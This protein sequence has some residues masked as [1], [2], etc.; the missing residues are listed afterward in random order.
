VFKVS[1]HLDEEESLSNSIVEGTLFTG[2]KMS[3]A[4]WTINAEEQQDLRSRAAR[5]N[6]KGCLPVLG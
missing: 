1:L 5:F 4:K 6:E 2:V 3:T